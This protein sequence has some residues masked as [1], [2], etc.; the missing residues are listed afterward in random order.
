MLLQ[1]FID[2]NV[3]TSGWLNGCLPEKFHRLGLVVFTSEVVP[4]YLRQRQTIYDVGGGKHP[5]L[6]AE[7]KAQ[8]GAKVIGIDVSRLELEAAEPGAY[9]SFLVSPIE[10]VRGDGDGELVICQTLLEHVQDTEQAF[11]AIHSLLAPGGCALIIVPCR[12]A[13]FARLNRLLP[14]SLKRRILFALFPKRHAASG[15][16]AKYDRCTPKMFDRLAETTGFRVLEVDYFYWNSYV[17]CFVPIYALWRVWSLL[18]YVTRGRQAC[19]S[20]LY[21]L[22]KPPLNLKTD[23]VEQPTARDGTVGPASPTHS[24]PPV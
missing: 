19:E 18:F 11:R 2:W 23:S 14:Q 10:Q 16:P 20:F 3:R 12:D 8:L 6:K 13:L 7:R 22:Q 4:R 15:F 17:G 24:R 9:D 21:V 1:K 5:F